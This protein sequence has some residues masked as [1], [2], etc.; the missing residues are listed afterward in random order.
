MQANPEKLKEALEAK[1]RE[2]QH[3]YPQPLMS[4]LPQEGE[5]TMLQ[6]DPRWLQDPES[7]ARLVKQVMLPAITGIG[8]KMVGTAIPAPESEEMEL[9]IINS[10]RIDHWT[11]PI[12][13]SA[14]EA[15]VIGEW[16]KTE[17]ANHSETSQELQKAIRDSSGKTNPAFIQLLEEQ[18]G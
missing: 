4:L 15:A 17:S 11:A 10:F 7:R 8:A 18:S 6:L 1:L 12:Y 2:E 13:I 5:N 9:T 14:Q 3:E 16:Q